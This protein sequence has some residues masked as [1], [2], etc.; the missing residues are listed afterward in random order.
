MTRMTVD[1]AVLDWMLDLRTP[2]LTDVATV[3]THSGGTV[4]AFLISAVVTVALLRARRTAEAVTVAGAMLSGWAVM[5]L[6]KLLFGR[7]RPP[8]PERLVD[9]DTYSFPSGHA[10]MSAI[11]ACVLGAVV[12]RVLAPGLRRLAVL[13]LLACYT[14]AVGMTRVY[15]AAHWLT[16]VVAGWALGV[17]WAGLW[18]WALSRRST[19]IDRV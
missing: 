4:A 17:A 2:W 1:R 7:Q 12:V 3:I 16:D 8:V 13:V 18:I 11:L 9:L 5:S 14:V 15:L 19:R 10:M 6:L